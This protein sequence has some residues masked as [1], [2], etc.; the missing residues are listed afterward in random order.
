MNRMRTFLSIILLILLSFQVFMAQ[1][2]A[3]E[4]QVQQKQVLGIATG[5]SASQ[6]T[7]SQNLLASGKITSKK[8]DLVTQK[9]SEV[10]GD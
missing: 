2:Y 1:A 8:I 6:N 10:L 7:P 3:A 4:N 9:F 5:K